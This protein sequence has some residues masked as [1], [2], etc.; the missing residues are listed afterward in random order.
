MTSF[1]ER[2]LDMHKRNMHPLTFVIAMVAGVLSIIM[3]FVTD[4]PH[5]I[6]M[7]IFILLLGRIYLTV[8]KGEI[9]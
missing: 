8:D 2:I 7:G 5:N 1:Y 4:T 3:G 6:S 9:S